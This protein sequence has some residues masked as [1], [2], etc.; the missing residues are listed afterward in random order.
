M[1]DLNK[2]STKLSKKVD[3]SVPLMKAFYENIVDD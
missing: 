3:N 1:N 2:I